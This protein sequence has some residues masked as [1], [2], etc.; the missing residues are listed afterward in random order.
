M[1]IYRSLQKKFVYQIAADNVS[2]AELGNDVS[3]RASPLEKKR[4]WLGITIPS[5]K[6]TIFHLY[7][8]SG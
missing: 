1:S 3:L 5:H 6:D 2:Y 7:A 4:E 8:S